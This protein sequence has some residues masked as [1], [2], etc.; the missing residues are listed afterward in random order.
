VGEEGV[1]APPGGA[2]SLHGSIDHL[3]E[4]CLVFP[5]LAAFIDRA[6][7]EGFIKPVHRSIITVDS[8]P[9]RLLDTLAAIRLPDAPKWITLDET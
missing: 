5:R 1:L 6:V 9:A 4:H 2:V 7:A 8:D 3:A